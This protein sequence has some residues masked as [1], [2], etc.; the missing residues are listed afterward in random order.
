MR[1]AVVAS[2]LPGVASALRREWQLRRDLSPVVSSDRIERLVA[3]GS[4]AGALAAKVCGAGGGG[5]LVLLVEDAADDAVRTAVTAAGGTPVAFRPDPVG[6][7]VAG[8]PPAAPD[9]ASGETC[10]PA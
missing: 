6:L 1:E 7:T 9:A 10:P 5:C 4:D 8:G 3:A 2:D